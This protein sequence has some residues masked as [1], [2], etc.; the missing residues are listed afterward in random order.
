[1]I[2]DPA[3]TY[4]SANSTGSLSFKPVADAS[5]TATI[6]VTVEDG[7]LDGDLGTAEDNAM[8]SRTF[9]VTV[10]PVNDDPT[11]ATL[12]NVTIDED[13]SEQTVNV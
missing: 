4:T 13:A 8:F 2:P 11:L 1:V 5:G 3:V 7:G 10:S 9:D 12:G 6:T